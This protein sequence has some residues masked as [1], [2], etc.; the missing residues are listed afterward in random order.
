[1]DRQQLMLKDNAW[2]T[3]VVLPHDAPSLVWRYFTDRA[4]FY[5]VHPH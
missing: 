5:R 3:F 4:S 2:Q 1:M